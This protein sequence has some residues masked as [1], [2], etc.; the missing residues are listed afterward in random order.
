MYGE[1]ERL[2]GGLE[3][4]DLD[5]NLPLIVGAGL[6]LRDVAE[7]DRLSPSIISSISLI[8]RPSSASSCLSRLRSLSVI[9]LRSLP[10]GLLGLDRDG[11]IVLSVGVGEGYL[12]LELLIVDD[13]EASR[14]REVLDMLTDADDE[15]TPDLHLRILDRGDSPLFAELLTVEAGEVFLVLDVLT[16]DAGPGCLS[17]DV[18]DVREVLAVGAGDGC[19]VL[20]VRTVEAGLGSLLLEVLSVLSV[21]SVLP[22]RDVP[23]VGVGEGRLR[24]GA[25]FGVLAWNSSSTLTFALS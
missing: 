24:G 17:L 6:E 3:W 20:E 14:V 7:S 4:R 5:L 12:D 21:L 10:D 23:A 16:V 8:E 25:I 22:V 15:G 11:L 1:G 13:G 2:L 9:G 19:L 18:L